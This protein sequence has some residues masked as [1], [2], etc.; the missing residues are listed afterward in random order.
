MERDFD[1]ALDLEVVKFERRGLLGRRWYFRLI[2]TRNNEKLSASEGYNST[3]ARD[4]M[5]DRLGDVIGCA[6]VDERN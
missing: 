4:K 5:A 3:R 1:P 6:V 2:D